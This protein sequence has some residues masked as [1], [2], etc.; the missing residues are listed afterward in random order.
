MCLQAAQ[1]FQAGLQ[2]LRLPQISLPVAQ[3]TQQQT[4]PNY[5]QPFGFTLVPILKRLLRE[6][7]PCAV[8]IE[9]AAKSEIQK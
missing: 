3:R 8:S 6:N 1:V 9:H 2:R 5:P 4:F 7:P